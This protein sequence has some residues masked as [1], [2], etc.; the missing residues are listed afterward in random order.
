[1]HMFPCRLKRSFLVPV[2]SWTHRQIVLQMY[3]R[4]AVRLCRHL[5][6]PTALDRKCVIKVRHI[7][8]F[9]ANLGSYQSFL[10]S[11]VPWKLPCVV[12]ESL[13]D[14]LEKPCALR[15]FNRYEHV[16]SCLYRVYLSCRNPY[17][18]F[19]IGIDRRFSYEVMPSVAEEGLATF[20]GKTSPR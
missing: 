12:M 4:C 7:E 2:S 5:L 16:L 15:L 14:P 10:S 9:G 11:E 13:Q 19:T 3:R 20:E 18:V 6:A 1:M 17:S 8:T